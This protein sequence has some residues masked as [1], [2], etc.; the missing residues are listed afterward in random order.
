MKLSRI[1]L[2]IILVFCLIMSTMVVMPQ[3][4]NAA[5]GDRITVS[6]NQFYAGDKP[7]WIN[8]VN[9]P[10]IIWDEFGSNFDYS[11]WDLEMCKLKNNGINAAR[12]WISCTGGVGINIDD[13]GYVTGATQ[14][15]WDHLDD[16]FEIASN[17]G[18][19][20]MATLMS[21]DHFKNTY[22]TH[23]RW[24]K[25]LQNNENIDSYIENYIKPFLKR[26]KDN[27]YLWSIDLMNEPD[28]VFEQADCGQ[29]SWDW[30]QTY[31][32]KAA[33][34]IHQNSDV[35]VTANLC[36]VK[37]MSESSAGA[38]GNMV[39]DSALMEKAGGNHLAKLDFYSPH[40]YPWMTEHFGNPFYMTPAEYHMDTDKPIVIAES[41][42]KGSEPDG[43]KTAVED[44]ENAYQNGW[45]GVMA[46]TS[47]GVD[48]NGDLDDLKAATN[49]M[50]D[51]HYQNIYPAIPTPEPIELPTPSTEPGEPSEKAPFN[52]TPFNV[53]C[54]VEAEEFDYGGEGVSYH[55]LSEVNEGGAYR[56]TTGVDIEI[57]SEG[58]YNIG[59]SKPGEWLEYTINVTTSDAYDIGIRVSTASDGVAM[60]LEFDGVETETIAIPNTGGW[61]NWR[62][63]KVE[64][65]YLQKGV[66]PMRICFETNDLNLSF[67]SIGMEIADPEP[68]E[69]PVPEKITLFD[70]GLGLGWQDWSWSCE[71]NFE[72]ASPVYSGSKSL[73]LTM[74]S[75]GALQIHTASG[76]VAVSSY[77]DLVFY[78]NGGDTGG[79]NLKVMA[80]TPTETMAPVNLNEFVE[81]GDVPAGEWKK[82]R[83]PLSALNIEDA[84]VVS[85]IIQSLSDTQ[86]PVFYLDQI[87]FLNLS[88]SSNEPMIIYD[89][90][91]DAD[92]DNWGWS[93]QVNPDCTEPVYSGSKS[94]A[95]T[96]DGWG[97]FRPRKRSGFVD[98]SQYTDLTFY[99]HGGA[100]GGQILDVF[101]S[102][103]STTPYINLSLNDYIEGGTITAGEWKKVRIPLEDLN[104]PDGQIM[105]IF[106]KSTIGSAQPVFYIDK[107]QFESIET[108]PGQ[109]PEPSTPPIPSPEPIRKPEPLTIISR[110]V[111][112]Y[113]K[114]QN[115]DAARA[116]D[117]NY[118]TY[119]RSNAPEEETWLAYNLSG[120]PADKRNEVLVVW[121]NGTGVYD[122]YP[123]GNN[124]YS[125]PRDYRIEVNSGDGASVPEEGWIA[126]ATVTDNMC[127][128]RQH[129]IDMEGYNWIRIS[130]SKSYGDRTGKNDDV[131]LQMDI[132]DTSDGVEDS[133]LFL[134]DSITEGGMKPSPIGSKGTWAQLIHHLDSNY[135]PV[136]E[137]GGIGGWRASDPLKKGADGKRHLDRW[138]EQFPGKFVVYSFGTND[139]G[140]DV[141]T[142]TFYKDMK[143]AVETIILAGKTPVIPMI[144]WLRSETHN[145][146]IP[147]YNAVIEQLYEEY[148]HIIPG[149]DFYEY[150]QNHQDLIS[151]DGIHPSTA[152]YEAYRQLWA[153]K[154]FEMV[155]SQPDETDPSLPEDNTTGEPS[156]SSPAA[157]PASDT[158]KIRPT[159]R[160]NAAIGRVSM[161]SINGAFEQAK[162][163]GDGIKKIVLE[164]EPAE[165]AQQYVQQIPGGI[166]RNADRVE[167]RVIEIKTP[168]GT[169]AVPENM[170]NTS[171]IGNVS[172]IEISIGMA[173]NTT[174]DSEIYKK[175][176]DRPVIELSAAFDGNPIEWENRDAP[177]EIAIDYTPT[178]EEL[179][180]PEHI[181]VWYIDGNGNL[182]SVPN[183]RYD[184][185]KGKVIFRTTHFSKYAV[186]YEKITFDDLADCSWA[187]RSIEVLASK[188]VMGSIQ[189]TA[190]NPKEKMTRGQFIMWL[191]NALGLNTQWDTNFSDADQ[192]E[193]N[194]EAIAVARKLGIALGDGSGN[195]YPNRELTRQDM[196]VLSARAVKI[197]KA[198]LAAGTLTALS[199][200][201]DEANIAPY[202]KTDV[203]AMVSAGFIRGSNGN[204][205]PNETATKAEA[206]RLLHTLYNQNW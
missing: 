80:A 2:S 54:I 9:T 162:D 60:H 169:I 178:P 72:C 180:D 111:P 132:Y 12:V 74:D 119:W 140:W 171:D 206:A 62:T 115:S 93:C 194:Y 134:G 183:G 203:A 89:E 6:G 52:G 90:G 48:S 57:C 147:S 142:S 126:K 141:G 100:E 188:G 102:D 84:Q 18:I 137:G 152:G 22:A 77:T 202:A 200:F 23:T 49:G 47:N 146:R 163:N 24:R 174:L 82:V 123:S 112:A 42:A 150:F 21:F 45:Q 11:Q 122:L 124:G 131:S 25:W 65:V 197:A 58:G 14:K 167:Q 160:K 97:A 179:E 94:L 36:M 39:S 51:N 35:L 46:W 164:M 156:A 43:G 88:E 64:D 56:K 59:Y 4:V 144:P 38:V 187:A 175:V 135:F 70:E 127:H 120:V 30:L 40:H 95:L 29:I 10:W 31:F 199:G 1:L 98:A 5:F 143:N 166:F 157:V 78:I 92:W 76:R 172:Q 20:I 196:I 85:V 87:E 149:P 26:Y 17:R 165:G 154:M 205:H 101:A 116:N 86:L 110:N 105:S 81:G 182:N 133:W 145:A 107:M 53:P 176:G 13:T 198:E 73:A 168:L 61:Q 173:D 91:I 34:A 19:Y 191:I 75:W 96:M 50:R 151:Y 193:A 15:H 125:I 63:V 189:G 106:L 195:F 117:D 68:S 113:A 114:H 8:G 37:Y 129:R 109:E 204:L 177:V 184:S 103:D 99:I 159:L 201:A 181:V 185:E 7:I 71:K 28:W 161:A 27:P 155:Y 67:I 79:Q 41:P 66:Q 136:Q 121:Y 128:S 16:L 192:T 118:S 190:F 158:V 108:D 153:E 69:P 138:L 44:Y 139:S 170:F 104:A 130:V 186:G 55:D 148:P 83:I 33:V 32:A 3:R